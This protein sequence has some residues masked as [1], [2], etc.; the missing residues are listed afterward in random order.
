MNEEPKP[1]DGAVVVAELRQALDAADRCIELAKREAAR[2]DASLRAQSEGGARIEQVF[3]DTTRKR[4]EQLSSLDLR[5]ELPPLPPEVPPE[6]QA[7]RPLPPEIENS[8]EGDLVE[9]A[10]SV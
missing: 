8:P 10:L 6:V 9:A 7:P 5:L 2:A 3:L 1:P 4:R